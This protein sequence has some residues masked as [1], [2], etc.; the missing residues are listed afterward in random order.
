MEDT[1]EAENFKDVHD[2]KLK[3][4]KMLTAEEIFEL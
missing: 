2:K 4:N 3:N 1:N